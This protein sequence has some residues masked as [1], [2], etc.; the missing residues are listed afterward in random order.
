MLIEQSR[1]S[2]L[3]IKK[4]VITKLTKSEGLTPET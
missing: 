4:F 3:P 2:T 1:M